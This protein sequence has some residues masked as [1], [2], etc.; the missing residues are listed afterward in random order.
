MATYK[1]L[2]A[3]VLL[4]STFSLKAAPVET[5]ADFFERTDDFFKNYAIDGD[6]KYAQ[7]KISPIVLQPLINFIGKQRI[8]KVDTY[9]RKAYLI[10]CYNLLV[11]HA[12][13]KNYPIERVED[14]EQ[15]FKRD[16]YSVGGEMITLDHL[17]YR[18]LLKDYKDPRLHFVLVCAAKGCPPIP[19]YAYTPGDLNNQMN[20]QCQSALDDPSFLKVNAEGCNIQLSPIFKW[21]KDDFFP[22]IPEFINA[23]RSQEIPRDCPVNFYDYDWTLNAWKGL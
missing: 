10:N 21:Y 16:K 22:S 15:F 18:L 13:L 7:L 2:T 14:T 12:V 20:T 17:E 5:L 6:I 1:L 3:I 11:I 19:S 8:D 23:H 4:I 9:R